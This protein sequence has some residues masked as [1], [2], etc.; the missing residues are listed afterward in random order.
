MNKAIE[1]G[2]SYG[3]CI[4]AAVN[5]IVTNKLL[6]YA[7]YDKF[8]DAVKVDETEF[9]SERSWMY[10]LYYIRYSTTVLPDSA[11]RESMMFDNVMKYIYDNA[12]VQWES[13]ATNP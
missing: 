8:G 4:D 7:L 12:N 2:K 10:Y 5:E 13:E 3:E 11:I 1:E 9:E 6:M